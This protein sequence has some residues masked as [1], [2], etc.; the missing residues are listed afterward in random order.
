MEHQQAPLLP[1]G[2]ESTG[3]GGKAALPSIWTDDDVGVAFS[4]ASHADRIFSPLDPIH[5][6]PLEGGLDNFSRNNDRCHL[7]TVHLEL[8]AGNRCLRRIVLIIVQ[9]FRL[10]NAPRGEDHNDER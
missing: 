5:P 7:L 8:R 4:T 10:A 3:A 6:G 9:K 1:I 2:V